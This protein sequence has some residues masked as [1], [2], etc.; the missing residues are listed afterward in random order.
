MRAGQRRLN[1]CPD[2]RPPLLQVWFAL[3]LQLLTFLLFI[4]G[5]KRRGDLMLLLRL[6]L[7]LIVATMKAPF[8]LP[9]KAW[10]LSV[11]ER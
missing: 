10:L 2:S 7:S 4:I 6:V 11:L 5:R 3:M 8:P 1:S 9:L